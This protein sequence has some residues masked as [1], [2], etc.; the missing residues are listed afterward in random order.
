LEWKTWRDTFVGIR[1]V[2]SSI[3]DDPIQRDDVASTKL[4]GN[5]DTFTVDESDRVQNNN[6]SSSHAADG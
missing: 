1:F 4:I 2:H 5:A 6:S 3:S